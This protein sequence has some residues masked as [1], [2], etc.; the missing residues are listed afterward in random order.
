[1]ENTSLFEEV[2][3]SESITEEIKSKIIDNKE[4]NIIPKFRPKYTEKLG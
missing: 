1:M 4:N 2:N 3:L